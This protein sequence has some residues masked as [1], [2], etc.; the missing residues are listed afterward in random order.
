MGTTKAG[1]SSGNGRPAASLL[2][3]AAT[4]AAAASAAPGLPVSA[5]GAVTYKALLYVP[6]KAPFDLWDRN[7]RQRRGHNKTYHVILLPISP[8]YANGRG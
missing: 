4:P 5:E 3:T 8:G 7:Q 2:T 1:R 6:S